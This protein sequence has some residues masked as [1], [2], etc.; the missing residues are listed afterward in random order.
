MLGPAIRSILLADST[1]SG[2]VG[3]RIYP[4][5]L[6]LQCS[7]PALTYSFISNPFQI[8]M[9]S[10]RCQINCFAADYMA[11]ETLTQAVEDALKFK[12]GKIQGVTI[13]IIY[14]IEP[15]GH[16]KDEKSGFFFIPYDFK[17]NYYTNQTR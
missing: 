12:Y 4:L 6:P 2:L 3:T 7:L 10:A 9:R 5:E 8:V 17:V 1:V 16:Y 11:R 14:P 13:E 15:Y